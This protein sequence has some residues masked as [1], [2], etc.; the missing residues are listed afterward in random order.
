MRDPVRGTIASASVGS[1]FRVA[2]ARLERRLKKKTDKQEPHLEK[3][4]Q[5]RLRGRLELSL[6]PAGELLRFNLGILLGRRVKYEQHFARE[7]RQ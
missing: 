4:H 7:A 1:S 5:V 6:K 3:G 2:G